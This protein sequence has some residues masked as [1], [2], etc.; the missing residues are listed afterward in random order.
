[1]IAGSGG[2]AGLWLRGRSPGTY[3]GPSEIPEI[4]EHTRAFPVC[5]G[6]RVY[7]GPEKHMNI[8]EYFQETGFDVLPAVPGRRAPS[9]D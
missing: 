1:M 5:P 2:I 8:K 9:R 6:P 3:P 4:F 7:Q